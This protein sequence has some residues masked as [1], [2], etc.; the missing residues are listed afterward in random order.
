MSSTCRQHNT[1]FKCNFAASHSAD[2]GE[3]VELS[4]MREFAICVSVYLTVRSSVP[5][6]HPMY[7]SVMAPVGLCV[8]V[9][10][11]PLAP[12]LVQDFLPVSRSTSLQRRCLRVSVYVCARAAEQCT[13]HK[14]SQHVSQISPA[15]QL[16]CLLA[17]L[18]ACP[19]LSSELS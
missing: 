14:F 6:A 3:R 10:V 5:T 2:T 13:A 9:R 8:R 11:R 18:P 4:T 15:C 16:S 12:A 17:C 7:A 19:C 1:N